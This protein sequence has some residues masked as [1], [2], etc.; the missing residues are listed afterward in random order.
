MNG[1]MNLFS[2]NSNI[3]DVLTDDEKGYFVEGCI[4]DYYESLSYPVNIVQ[5]Q[6]ENGAVSQ[7]LNWDKTIVVPDI[8]VENRYDELFFIESK[9]FWRNY[10]S[11][12]NYKTYR[13]KKKSLNEYLSFY[14]KVFPR[15]SLEGYS[16][17][18]VGF[19][20]CAYDE[21]LNG[22]MKIFLVPFEN[23]VN[24][25]WFENKGYVEWNKKDIESS[26]SKKIK[27]DFRYS[28]K[29]KVFSSKFTKDILGKERKKLFVTKEYLDDLIE[30]W[31]NQTWSW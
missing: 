6:N 9:S 28:K 7:R 2:M 22:T 29:Y 10:Y 19:S 23:L 17:I 5:T 20:D 18:Y 15:K 26:S 21:F 25:N 11:S 3:N 31:E 27:I 8:L 30:Y 12:I 1:E 14:N 4:Y 24:L 13:V 16:N